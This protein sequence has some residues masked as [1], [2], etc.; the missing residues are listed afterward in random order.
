MMV[1]S[2]DLGAVIFFLLFVF[3]IVLASVY[4]SIT[5]WKE[6]HKQRKLEKETSK[7]DSEIIS[8]A[9]SGIR[10]GKFKL[11]P[12]GVK[13]YVLYAEYEKWTGDIHNTYAEHKYQPAGEEDVKAYYQKMTHELP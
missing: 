10:T 11:V 3:F 1:F 13:E 9:P 2:L 12:H 5:D 4:I 8:D 7:E 6:R